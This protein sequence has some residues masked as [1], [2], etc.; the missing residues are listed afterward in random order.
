MAVL[1]RLVDFSSGSYRINGV[2]ARKM[3]ASD[4]HDRTSAIFQSFCR[5]EHAS[6]RENTAVGDVMTLEGNST[7]QKELEDRV[8]G[9][10]EAAGAKKFID[11]FSDGLTTL[12]EA[13]GVGRTKHNHYLQHYDHPPPP[14]ASTSLQFQGVRPLYDS[15]NN[16]ALLQPNGDTGT[17]RLSGGQVSFDA[18]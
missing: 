13:E 18:P 15:R 12:L 17:A 5:F 4:L 10:L 7:S 1:A 3:D 8:W 6:A 2:D 14:Y 16:F 9:A 11:G